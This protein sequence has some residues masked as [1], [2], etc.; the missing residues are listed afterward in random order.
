MFYVVSM[1]YTDETAYARAKIVV[2][3]G[4]DLFIERDKKRHMGICEILS[5]IVENCAFNLFLSR[6]LCPYGLV[7]FYGGFKLIYVRDK[8][9]WNDKLIIQMY[10]I[11]S[12]LYDF[13]YRRLDVVCLSRFL[14]QFE[15]DLPS[16]LITA[17]NK[18]LYIGYIRALEL[19]F[20]YALSRS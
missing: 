15:H 3:M 4:I 11:K 17:E 5:Y 18:I 13:L 12:E 9:T 16:L 1:I 19:M 10:G 7:H 20:S 8:S 6:F 2:T 14:A